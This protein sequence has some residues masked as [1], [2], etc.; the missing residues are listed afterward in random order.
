MAQF[1]SDEQR[2]GIEFTLKTLCAIESGDDSAS[3]EEE[4]EQARKKP[5]SAK[6]RRKN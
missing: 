1:T 3:V 2:K 5:A 4:P 6:A